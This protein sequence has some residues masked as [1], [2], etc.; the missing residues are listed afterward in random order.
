M[1]QLNKIVTNFPMSLTDE[2]NRNLALTLSAVVEGGGG[3]GSADAIW[4][5]AVNEDGIVTWTW[6]ENP[7]PLIPP[8][9]ANIKGPR[10]E[11]GAPG[12]D[13][14]NGTNG[15]DGKDGKDGTDGKDGEDGKTPQIQI[16]S[17]NAHWEWRYSG[18]SEWTDLGVVASGAVGPQ[19]IPGVSGASGAPGAKGE[20]GEDGVSPSVTTSELPSS[21]AHPQGGTSV[22]ITDKTGDHQFDV[23]NGI[24]GEGASVN[25][26]DGSGIHIEQN[27]INYTIG[28]SADYALRTELPDLTPY[29]TSA[30]VEEQGYL[31]RPDLADYATETYVNEASANALSET[32]SWVGEQGF[33]KAVPAGYATETYANNASA[34]ALSQAKSWV[35]SEGYLKSVSSSGSIQGNGSSSSPLIL[36]TSAEQALAAV[37]GKVSKPTPKQQQGAYV[38]WDRGPGQQWSDFGVAA[39]SWANN[40]LFDSESPIVNGI[41]GL[42]AGLVPGEFSDVYEVGIDTTNMAANKQYGFTTSGWTEVVVPSVTGYLPTSGGTVSGQLEV[43]GGSNFDQQFLKLTREGVTGHARLGL[44]QYGALALKSDDSSNH[45]TQVNISPN[46][47]NDQL[48]QVQHNGNAVGNLIPA[49]IHQGSYTPTSA[50]GILHIVLES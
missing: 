27:G 25:L 24:N 42:S 38:V 30:W 28:V 8:A 5:P 14:T 29:A 21:T 7:N 3:G 39:S 37:D 17:S 16:N 49:Q 1:S 34:N 46:N 40:F 10:G 45:T 36:K 31:T 23:W 26:L 43:H 44:G 2:E 41:N 19:G 35:Q 50:D 9:S 11:S 48:I 18:A 12:R 15:T 22:T 33:L 4:K 47:S 6:D 20:D 13:G 32:E